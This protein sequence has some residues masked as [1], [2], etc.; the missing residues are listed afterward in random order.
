MRA[1]PDAPGPALF[2]GLRRY[3]P[4]LLAI[5]WLVAGYVHYA[6]GTA[7]SLSADHYRA[8]AFPAFRYSDIIWLYLRDH[9]SARPVPYLDYSLEYPPLTG[10]LSWLLSWLPG[11]PVYFAGA[12]MVLAASALLTTWALDRLPGSNPWLF[13]ASP[14]LFFYTGHQWDLAAIAVT[15][16]SLLALQTGRRSAGLVGLALGVSLKL[17]P[18]VFFVA[19]TVESLRDRRWRQAMRD[20][21]I[22]VVVTAVLNA[23]VA[24][25]NREGWSFFFR[26]NRERL[27]DSGVWVLWRDVATADLT[28]WSMVAALSAGAALTLLALRQKGPLTIPLGATYLVW[29]LLL[30]KTFTTHLM[31]WAILAIALVSAPMWLWVLTTGIDAAGF[32]IGNYLNLYNVPAYQHAPLIRTAVEHLYDPLQLAR[33]GVL[34]AAAIWLVQLLRDPDQRDCFSS[35][36]SP[37]ARNHPAPRFLPLGA[38]TL[39][40]RERWSAA[41]TATLVFTAA[42][43]VMTWPYVANATSA[44]AVGF[45][46]FLQIW[47]S[48][49][50]QHALATDPRGLFA[51]NMFYPFSQSLAYTDANVPGALLALPIRAVTG[52]PIL[53]NSILVLA[54]FV[55]A[56][57]GT[58]LLVRYVTGNQAVSLV[59]GLAYAF[60]PYRMIHL[61]HLNWL[62]GALVPWFILALLR[63]IDRPNTSRA[64]I[65]G[66]L[67]AIITLISFYF[68]PQLALIAITVSA[69]VW[70]SRHTW[71]NLPFWRASAIAAAVAL[72]LAFPFLVPYIQ[73]HQQQRLERTL[74]DAEQYKALPGSYVQLAPWDTPNALQSAFGVRTAPNLS[75]T[76]V[77][78]ARHADGHQHAEIVTEDALYPG[79]LIIA[80]AGIAVVWGRPRWLVVASAAIAAVAGLL[81]FGPSWGP[82]HADNPPLP[83]A[84]LFEHVTLVRAMRVPARL[85][86]LVDLMLVLMAALGMQ[87]SWHCVGGRLRDESRTLAGLA[88]TLLLSGFV[89]ADLWTGPVPLEGV[90]RAPVTMSG[91]VWLASQPP[92]PVMEFPAE[93]VFADPAAASVRRHSGEALLRSTIHWLPMVN[94][95][96]GFI[97]R[98][99]SD[100]I[101]RFVG[102]LPRRDG[103][104]TG[105]LSHLDARSVRLLQQLGVRYAVFNLDQY[106]DEDWPAVQG[107]LDT[108]VERGD[109]ELGGI[110]GNQQIY[111]VTPTLPAPASPRISLFAPT[112]VT[113]EDPWSPWIGVE[114]PET[115]TTLALT[116]PAQL[117]LDWYDDAG[118]LLRTS[119]QIVPLP[120]VMDDAALLCSVRECLTSRPFADLR[121][122][123]HPERRDAWIPDQPGHYVVRARLS[124]DTPL[125][126]QIDL[127]VVDGADEVTARGGDDP[128]RWA[129]CIEE[130]A[131]PVN[132]PGLPPFDLADTAVTLAGNTVG[133]EFTVTARHDAPVRAWF[134]LSPRGL[135]DPWQVAAYQ[136]PIEEEVVRAGAPERFEWSLTL[137]ASLAPGAYDL[138][139]WVHYQSGGT[140]HHAVGG[141]ATTDAVIV[142]ADGTLRRSG[143]VRLEMRE[144]AISIPRD[145][146]YALPIRVAGMHDSPTCWLRWSIR[147]VNGDRD[148]D[149]VTTCE[150]PVLRLPLGLP[151]GAYRLTVGASV[152]DGQAAQ[153]S[154]GVTAEVTVI[155]STHARAR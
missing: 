83:Y 26:W 142:N 14:A 50:I 97:P 148:S 95:N 62:E 4:Y 87:A 113:P 2:S 130:F 6:P 138:T 145:V 128:H 64:L 25:V 110:H 102:E 122:L 38:Q 153:L 76:E 91:A 150:D 120:A 8:W 117:T 72:A 155:E 82:P 114:A 149:G 147:Q 74:T 139:V 109:L 3:G 44:T 15:A 34:G 106:A 146:A 80:F 29:W 58:F 39:D 59:A 54:S 99:Y 36:P 81:S 19:L 96:S 152:G 71:P 86:G 65:A 140:W 35:Q 136:S 24:V 132:N 154:D 12:Y 37:Q 5:L 63:M 11:L 31:L 143:P 57:L 52:D 104:I 27:A 49:W 151:L 40:R 67:A 45:D 121:L 137:P 78:Q 93:S 133:V 18:I 13:A 126:C 73:V 41:V 89:L 118:K 46:P 144:D 98:A 119:H 135:P 90:D 70:V 112:L 9:L 108:L 47:L 111:T 60:L 94:G 22:F 1:A 33:T 23:P 79:L 125:S 42:A 75:L 141:P 115:P 53:T 77:G 105:P 85:G 20:T 21:V 88:L 123:P 68:A 7:Y 92:G 32:Q 66:V 116:M 129:A 10:L 101:E 51:A 103:S 84:W 48:E 134:I 17:F 131:F 69:S 107:E 28:R 43:V 100:F 16:I 30:N 124:G 55:A 56:A 61:W 127:D